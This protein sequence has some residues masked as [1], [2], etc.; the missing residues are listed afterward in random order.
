M[1]KEL[2]FMAMILL[3]ALPVYAS[4]KPNVVVSD[5]R[6]DGAAAVGKDFTLTVTFKNLEPTVCAKQ[7]S[8]N[9]E[10]SFPFIAKGVG[11]IS[12]GDLCYGDSA[13]ASFPLKADPTG[14]GG[15]Y[16]VKVNTDYQTPTFIQYTG[17]DIVNIY[18]QGSPKLDARI[19][20]SDP[21]DVYPGDTGMLT[22]TIDN[23]GDFRA[24]SVYA[25]FSASS[26]ID[27]KW[28][29]STS[30][31]GQIDAKQSKTATVAI[32]VPKDAP[33]KDYPMQMKLTYLDENN[34]QQAKNFDFTVK[35][36]KKAKFDTSGVSDGYYPNQNG[37]EL[38]L[39]LLNTGTD[40]AYKLKVRIVPQFPFSTDGSVH[41]LDSLDVS[42]K[43]NMQF[44]LDTDKDAT[45]GRY[46]LDLL[47]NYEDEQGKQM[48][49]TAKVALEIRPKTRFMS[50]FLDFWLLWVIVIIVVAINVSKRMKKKK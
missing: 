28:A 35:V 49:D 8:T 19:T 40:K 25:E 7:L 15:Y 4:V 39:M 11:T 33:S 21:I 31:I 44:T 46:S 12:V 38:G 47:I 43:Q 20:G 14:V 24:G 26:P 1:R 5:Y 27:V 36:K 16:Q 18:L 17:S 34:V 29:K 37:K 42:Q 2:M 3:L 32:E 23:N 48:Q 22:V 30:S 13:T 41:Y 50:V 9:V 10:S 45:P 6:I